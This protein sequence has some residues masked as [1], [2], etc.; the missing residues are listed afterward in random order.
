MGGAG[1]R[2]QTHCEHGADSWVSAD[3]LDLSLVLVLHLHCHIVRVFA[4]YF[5]FQHFA[6][7][8]TT[9]NEQHQ[10]TL[11]Y[12]QRAITLDRHYRELVSRYHRTTGPDPCC[13]THR[14]RV[15]YTVQGRD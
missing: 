2:Q 4:Q 1:T 8:T 6:K 14:G 13:S 11:P 15:Q 12:S 10:H 5:V 7:S 3:C 9:T